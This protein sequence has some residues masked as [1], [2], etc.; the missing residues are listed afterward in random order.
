MRIFD[1]EIVKIIK[2][3]VNMFQG[4]IFNLTKKAKL[5]KRNSKFHILIYLFTSREE[6]K[7]QIHGTLMMLTD[8]SRHLMIYKCQKFGINT[9]WGDSNVRFK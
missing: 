1:H 8:K 6:E 5:L 2:W 4:N 9:G 3:I 7:Y